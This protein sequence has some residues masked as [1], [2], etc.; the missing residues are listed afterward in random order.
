MINSQKYELISSK[1]ETLLDN[2]YYG[3]VANIKFV[4]LHNLKLIVIT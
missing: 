3:S 1:Y 4:M 2:Q